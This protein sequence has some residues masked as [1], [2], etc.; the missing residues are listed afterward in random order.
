VGQAHYACACKG[1]RT[2]ARQILVVIC[3]KGVTEREQHD[4]SQDRAKSGDEKSSRD[5]NA[6]SEGSPK[7]VDGHARSDA[8]NQPDIV[9]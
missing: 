7:E 9:E 6:S 8:G 4:E 2:D 1:D 5:F 3:H